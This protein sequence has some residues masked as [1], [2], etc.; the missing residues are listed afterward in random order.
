MGYKPI[1]TSPARDDVRISP[2][3]PLL[4]KGIEPR[5]K[6]ARQTPTKASRTRV[7][8]LENPGSLIV[9]RV[10]SNAPLLLKGIEP[11]PER[12][13]TGRRRHA[14]AAR[15]RTTPLS[16]ASHRSALLHLRASNRARS[17][18]GRHQRRRRGH[19]LATWR[20]Q[21]ASL[22][23]ASHRT[24]RYYLRASNRAREG[25]GRTGRGERQSVA[26]GTPSH[27]TSF[28]SHPSAGLRKTPSNQR[29]FDTRPHTRNPQPA[30]P[31]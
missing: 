27:L 2:D 29:R 17:E 23:F 6:R 14:S 7:S 30:L 8:H 5:S 20:T 1:G 18:R 22:S 28:A 4:L 26:S 31:W 16:F 19:A 9:V 21:A 3:A 11:S 10:S 15:N 25:P 13:W 12:I 24:P